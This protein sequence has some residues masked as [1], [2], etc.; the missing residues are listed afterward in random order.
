[1]TAIEAASVDG[2]SIE[3][4]LYRLTDSGWEAATDLKVGDK[5]KIELL[6]HAD[7]A[8]DYVA[9]DDNRAA[10]LEPVDQL[11]TPL[12]SEGIC[13]YRE[14]RD[15]ATNIFISTLPAGTYRLSYEMWV[16]SAGT[17]A[18]GIATL[19]SQYAP[20]LTAHSSGSLISVAPQ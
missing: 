8:V 16:N 15:S 13:F 11:P 10:C 9:I 2:L 12:W 19:Q 17:F 14:N 3:K 18:S 5:V 6:I 20:A 1:M 4:Q 7:R